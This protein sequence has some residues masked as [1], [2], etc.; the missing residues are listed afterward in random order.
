MCT[1]CLLSCCV[2]F[3]WGCFL[4]ENHVR[5]NLRSTLNRAGCS[6][7]C[8]QRNNGTDSHTDIIS[9]TENAHGALFIMRRWRRGESGWFPRNPMTCR[10]ICRTICRTTCSPSWILIQL[11]FPTKHTQHSSDWPFP[12]HN[13]QEIPEVWYKLSSFHLKSKSSEHSQVQVVSQLL[14]VSLMSTCVKTFLLLQCQ[15]TQH[16]GQQIT[17][18]GSERH[19]SGWRTVTRWGDVLYWRQ[20]SSCLM[21]TMQNL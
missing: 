4:P 7:K 16:T 5:N 3:F 20:T 18:F 1:A 15:E 6:I 2:C 8:E 19:E 21:D 11:M 9:E 12:V 13:K 14:A 17:E 10:T